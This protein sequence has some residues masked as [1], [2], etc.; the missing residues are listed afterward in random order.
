MVEDS[1][2]CKEIQVEN[3]F[4]NYENTPR[5]DQKAPLARMALAFFYPA[6]SWHYPRRP[7]C[8]RSNSKAI[9]TFRSRLGDFTK[10]LTGFPHECLLSK[11]IIFT[12]LYCNSN[13]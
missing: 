1:N 5:Y 6:A 2:I 10:L 3:P 4:I 7:S 12:I 13:K 9:D 8:L 11:Y